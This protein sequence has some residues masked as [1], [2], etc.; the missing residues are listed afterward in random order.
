MSLK[1]PSAST[2]L[3][4]A[5]I[6]AV[7]SLAAY[8]LFPVLSLSQGASGFSLGTALGAFLGS[9]LLSLFGSS[10]SAPKARA[11]NTP[12]ETQ[13]IFVGN[14]AFKASRDELRDLFARY[15]TVHSVRIMT[16]RATRR[17]RGFGFVEMSVGDAK[18]AI[19]ALDGQ[20]FHGRAMRV[21]QG[22]ER[23]P[24]QNAA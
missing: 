24:E 13:S 4:I 6:T 5:L 22:N 15:G 12:G 20:E 1:T 21:N 2:L 18:R 14:L 19:K 3:K 7:L 10:A 16:D 11:D 9:L 8:L 23:R 17:P